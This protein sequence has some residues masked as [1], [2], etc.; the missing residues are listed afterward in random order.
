MRRRADVLGRLYVVYHEAND[1]HFSGLLPTVP[2]HLR[3][4]QS[5]RGRVGSVGEFVP[6]P[7]T[8]QP[9]YL[10]L[11]EE[12]ALTASWSDVRDVVLHEM[13]HV[14]QAVQG[15]H[16]KHGPSFK[17]MAKRLGISGRSVD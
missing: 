7:F 9:A 3:G 17:R 13:V 11:H 5:K 8:G 4:I 10:I 15:H 14:W 2:I 1:R 12:F 6:H 16:D